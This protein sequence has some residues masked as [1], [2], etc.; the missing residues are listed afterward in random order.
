MADEVDSCV[1]PAGGPL[2][3]E[4]A[5][6][7][8]EPSTAKEKPRMQTARVGR[9]APDF[10]APAYVAGDGF[11]NVKLSDY[12]GQWVVLCFYPGDFTFV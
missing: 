3:E 10:E 12:Q 5:P 7:E 4:P 6:S 8:G 2:A 1:K 11:K 9:P